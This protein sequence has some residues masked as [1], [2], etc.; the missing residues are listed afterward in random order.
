V[1][2]QQ[3]LAAA[4]MLNAVCERLLLLAVCCWL[5]IDVSMCVV[6]SCTELVCQAS[7]VEDYT[8]LDCSSDRLLAHT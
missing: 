1:R 5:A 2:W 3:R 6:V 4:E 8:L 7:V